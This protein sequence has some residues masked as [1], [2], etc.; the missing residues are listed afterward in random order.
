MNET[1]IDRIEKIHPTPGDVIVLTLSKNCLEPDVLDKLREEL[2]RIKRTLPADINIFVLEPGMRM[3]IGHD[4]A[5]S[6]LLTELAEG[7]FDEHGRL[8]IPVADMSLKGKTVSEIAQKA[9]SA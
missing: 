8:A 4:D 6:R 2:V 5:K 1:L 7:I 9:L 3:E